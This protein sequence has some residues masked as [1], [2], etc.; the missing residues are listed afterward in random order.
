M[1][2]TR[3]GWIVLI[4]AT[5][6]GCAARKPPA[7]VP[8]AYPFSEVRAVT[9]MPIVDSRSGEKA[10]ID[11]EKLRAQAEKQL[12]G[13]RYRVTLDADAASLADMNVDDINEM[14]PDL[15]RKTAPSEQRWVMIL[16]LEDVAT[17]ITF[18][19]TGNAEMTGFLFDKQSGKLA[20]KNKG[21]GKAGQGGLAGMMMKGMMKGEALSAA[22]TNLLLPV[23]EQPGQTE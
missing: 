20:W 19:S 17:K 5:L 4:A 18:G 6:A 13:K 11:F 14:T 10:R 12:T 15:V 3:V 23:P 21:I 16:C 2:T 22:L 8:A 1:R 7:T 9:L